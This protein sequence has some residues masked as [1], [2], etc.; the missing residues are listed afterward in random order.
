MFENNYFSQIDGKVSKLTF[1]V[2]NGNSEDVKISLYTKHAKSAYEM[3]AEYT[4]KAGERKLID[5][6]LTN[7]SWTKKG[8]LNSVRFVFDEGE[9]SSNKTLYVESFLVYYK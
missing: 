5:V 4:L 3:N 2:Y 7:V 8:K 1:V 9:V 6:S